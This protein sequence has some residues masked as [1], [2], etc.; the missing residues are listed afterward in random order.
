MC[1][2]DDN[3]K[4]VAD[5]STDISWY[6]W[7]WSTGPTEALELA[8]SIP[9]AQ[10]M[11]SGRKGPNPETKRRKEWSFLGPLCHQRQSGRWATAPDGSA[12]PG[13]RW[14][15]RLG[16]QGQINKTE[17]SDCCSVACHPEKA[18]KTS[19]RGTISIA[20]DQNIQRRLS[21]KT[22]GQ[23]RGVDSLI[24]WLELWWNNKATLN[25]QVLKS[26]WSDKILIPTPSSM[27]FIFSPTALTVFS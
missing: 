12:D 23:L 4:W 20:K 21:G 9:K 1:W 6:F 19:W 25:F 7:P 15:F 24:V 8:E 18:S 14:P 16:F 3:C 11:Y 22:V 13:A 27:L 26:S 10:D 5:I 17:E 2:A